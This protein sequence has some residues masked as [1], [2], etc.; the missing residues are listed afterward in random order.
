MN[1][2]RLVFYSDN[3][4]LVGELFLPKG[5]GPWPGVVLCHG[6]GSRKERHSDFATFA[7]ARGIAVLA[8]DQRG[9]GESDGRLDGRAWADVESALAQLAAH[10][11][12]D[13]RRLG[14]R[15]SSLGGLYAI[16]AA[17]R[18]PAVRACVAICP[19]RED[20]LLAR[21]G[22][23]TPGADTISIPEV[24]LDALGLSAYLRETD[25]RAAVALIQPRP[26]L[27]IHCQQDEV[28]PAS[29]S[30]DLYRRAGEP[31]ELWLIPGGSHTTAQHDNG[32][33][34]RTVAWLHARLTP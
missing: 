7:A 29:V 17:S 24:R 3:I 18:L 10:P 8:F 19:A 5:D 1:R 22:L 27:L 23:D 25:G 6:L 30:R 12:V 11:E 15:G 14:V 13:G 33:H 34:E 9:H 28:V 4:R 2:T 21:L 20:L 26:L 31:K 32:V 16:H